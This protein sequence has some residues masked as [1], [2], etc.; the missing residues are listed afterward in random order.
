MS[1]ISHLSLA[2]LF[3]SANKKSSPNPLD[4]P[5]SARRAMERANEARPFNIN[6]DAHGTR[7]WHT[8]TSKKTAKVKK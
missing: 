4:M 1:I 7:P 8:Y 3:K 5:D 2:R 6:R